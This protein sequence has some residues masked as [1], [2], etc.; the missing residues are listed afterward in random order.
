METR[1]RQSPEE[2]LKHLLLSH[3]LDLLA[4]LEERLGRI[5]DRVGDDKAFQASVHRVIVGVLQDA[6]VRDHERLS[7]I[8]APLVVSSLREEIRSSRDM[9]VEALYPLTGRLVSTAVRNA[10]LE[11]L[12]SIDTRLTQA[13][14]LTRLRIRLQALF[15][16][17][18][19]AE[20][21]LQRFPPFEVDD[22]MVVHRPTGLLVVRAEEDAED[23]ESGIDSDLVG[24]M[25]SAI[26]SFTRDAFAESEPGELSTL[27]FG[28]SSLFIRSSPTITLAVKTSGTAPRLFEM[29]LEEAFVGLLERWGT[30]L[31]EFEGDLD[32]E[33]RIDLVDDLRRGVREAVAAGRRDAPRRSIKKAAT[34]LLV[35]L[36]AGG[37]VLGRWLLDVRAAG[38]V[39]AETRRVETL[40]SD[41]IAMAPSVSGYP[42]QVQ[43]D[44]E[45]RVLR[46]TGLAP[47][48]DERDALERALLE[49]L[50]DAGLDYRVNTL[51]KA[52]PP[53]TE[54]LQK[55]THANV[56]FFT[57]GAIPRDEV[58]V[59]A[60]LEE[61]AGLLLATPEEV[62]LRVVGYADP[63]GS[64]AINERLTMERAEY[65][66]SRLEKL[67]VP[68]SRMVVL[69]R[70]GEQFLT[71]V[72]GEGSESR[73]TEFEV[74]L[75]GS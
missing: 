69:G 20:L 54:R 23:D 55:W 34:L 38:Q 53:A 18:S 9:M 51:P 35:L 10:F 7:G 44:A 12:E 24:G 25:L 26:M 6:G 17:R 73:R 63:L 60:R 48:Y 59:Q 2:E 42:F 28:G 33:R 49:K 62:R 3:E 16:G 29:R 45:S 32:P 21:L 71:N 64:R 68:R 58:D 47:G 22:A 37:V 31:S 70:P 14:S 39:E 46:V 15:T 52:V 40:A 19:Q 4:K 50:P 41:T 67:G 75:T 30:D 56:I 61:L 36:V 5:Q 57:S 66:A 1:H 72:V 8:L 65:A 74:I 43:F 13:F 27:E 11:L